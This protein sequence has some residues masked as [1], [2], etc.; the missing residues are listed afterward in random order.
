MFSQ[1]W[2]PAKIN[3]FKKSFHFYVTIEHFFK[4]KN[5]PKHIN[6]DALNDYQITNEIKMVDAIKEDELLL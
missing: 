5:S 3:K 2:T 4:Q 6:K 1:M